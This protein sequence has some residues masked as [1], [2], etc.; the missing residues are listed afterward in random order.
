M[1][2]HI[3][4]LGDN[5]PLVLAAT[6]GRAKSPLLRSILKQVAALQLF[7]GTHVH[8]RWIPSELNVA[9]APSRG[10][11]LGSSARSSKQVAAVSPNEANVS[12]LN[13]RI[14]GHRQAAPVLSSCGLG[15]DGA[16]AGR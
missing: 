6:I 13:K 4:F 2:K 11:W 14:H 12:A 16:L 10:I 9:D 7:T 15:S 3:L 5:L 1:G 8:V